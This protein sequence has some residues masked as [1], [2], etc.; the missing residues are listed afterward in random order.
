MRALDV[1]DFKTRSQYT[2]R[3]GIVV[4]YSKHL[5][6]LRLVVETM[7][8]EK[9][10]RDNPSFGIAISRPYFD[11]PQAAE[12]ELDGF[13][14]NPEEHVTFVGGWG[15]ERKR[16]IANALRKMRPLYRAPF[17]GG[18]FPLEST[19]DIVLYNEI[20]M[21]VVESQEPDGTFKWGDFPYGG[22]VWVSAGG[23]SI[24][25]SVSGLHP[26]DDHM[27]AQMYANMILKWILI[28]QGLHAA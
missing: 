4:D 2:C 19:L 22:G 1:S 23:V 28:G 24:C 13:E 11:G 10:I 15:D 14:Y 25:C 17:E 21:D 6:K 12:D 3:N 7:A 20:F 5:T 9:I 26:I 16:Y 27:I 18:H 8:A